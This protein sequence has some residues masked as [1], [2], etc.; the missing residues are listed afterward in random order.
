MNENR[1]ITIAKRI[2]QEL[3]SGQTVNLG[4]GIPTL[5]PDYLDDKQLVLQ[6][7]NGLLGM[8]PTPPPGQVNMDLISASK[9]PIT[10]ETG[11]SLFDSSA[12]FAMI[13]GGHI[14]VAVLG[15]LQVDRTGEIANWAVPGATILGVGG[16]MDLVA[17]ANKI[18]VATLH[19][20]K[21]GEPK[22]VEELTYPTSGIRK[23]D[24]VVT[25]HAVFRFEEGSMYLVE[26]LSDLPLDELQEITGAPFQVGLREPDKQEEAAE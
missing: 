22:L 20:S 9:D 2:V 8:G 14:D 25:E 21:H 26:Q 3:E 5:I 15:A 17:G 16:A 13:R 18:I 7:E 4:V 12:S 6:S 11:A 19:S 1:R 23:A 24:L 10:M